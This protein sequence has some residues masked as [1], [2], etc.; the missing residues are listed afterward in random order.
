MTTR[1][2]D[3]AVE[4]TTAVLANQIGAVSQPS[5]PLWDGLMMFNGALEKI[6]RTDLHSGNVYVSHSGRTKSKSRM[7]TGYTDAIPH[8]SAFLITQIIQRR[9]L[10]KRK[11]LYIS[12]SGKT[13]WWKCL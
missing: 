6:G 10:L 11:S 1:A 2:I 5:A 3:V 12:G 7:W 9:K 8:H 4:K 13:K